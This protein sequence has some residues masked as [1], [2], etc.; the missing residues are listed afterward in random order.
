MLLKI[1]LRD[2]KYGPALVIKT[3]ETGGS[4]VL[5]FRIDPMERLKAT[6][7]EFLVLHRVYNE[8]PDLG[9]DAKTISSASPLA[10]QTNPT[11][12]SSEEVESEIDDRQESEVNSKLNTYL[13]TAFLAGGSSSASGERRTSSRHPV[14]CKEL[15][16]AM[17]RIRDGYKLRD[18]WD[19]LP[20][21]RILTET[22]E[23]EEEEE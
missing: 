13:A 23:E 6:Y 9:V 15:G 1:Y 16:F 20:A 17:E 19:V 7:Q 21:N 14:Y 18:L 5:G 22:T 3:A 11:P 4:Y 12:S 8:N 2:S 10:G